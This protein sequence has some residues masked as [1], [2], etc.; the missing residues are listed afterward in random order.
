MRCL[1]RPEKLKCLE[2][3]KR[4]NIEWSSFITLNGGKDYKQVKEKLEE[5]QQKLCVYCESKLNESHIEHFEALLDD[6]TT[7]F[8]H[9]SHNGIVIHRYG[10]PTVEN[11]IQAKHRS[12]KKKVNR[13]KSK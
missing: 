9:A 5:M 8:N 3:A 10:E 7:N 11:I 13:N 4:E 2:R 1:V 12:I 6:T